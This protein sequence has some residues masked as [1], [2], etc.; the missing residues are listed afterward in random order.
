VVTEDLL[1]IP[2]VDT[3]VVLATS[4]ETGVVV[5][6]ELLAMLDT[7]V[8]LVATVVVRAPVDTEGATVVVVEGATV[9]VVEG[10]AVVVVEGAAVVVV[11]GAVVVVVV[12]AVVVVVE[13]VE[14]VGTVIVFVSMVTAPLIARARPIN[15]VPETSVIDVVARMVPANAVPAPNVADDP[16]CQNTL[17]A[18]APFSKTTELPDPVVNV[19]PAWKI[20]T[21][22][23][24]P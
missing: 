10:A 19:D 16:T 21:E 1:E 8:A 2:M 24:L 22:F 20:Q 13:G 14:H 6:E 17:H 5:A 7:P 4:E 23:A 3:S 11:A 15:D 12:G 18:C 9:V